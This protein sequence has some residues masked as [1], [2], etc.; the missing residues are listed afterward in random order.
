MSFSSDEREDEATE[1]SLEEEIDGTR[2]S[3]PEDCP[4]NQPAPDPVTAPCD[5]MTKS[6]VVGNFII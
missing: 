4:Q 5:S 3:L 6:S 2:G 1:H